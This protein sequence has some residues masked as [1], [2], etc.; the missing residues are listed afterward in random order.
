MK[1]EN[2]QPINF[3]LRTDGFKI[4]SLPN[5]KEVVDSLIFSVQ[6]TFGQ[7]NKKIDVSNHHLFEIYQTNCKIFPKT[8]IALK[9]GKEP[10][11]GSASLLFNDIPNRPQYAPCLSFLWVDRSYQSNGIGSA[12]T[13]IIEK[14]AKN[15]E[16]DHIFLQTSTK[17]AFAFY[18][19]RG[20]KLIENLRIISESHVVMTKAL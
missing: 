7:I 4:Q 18:K 12:L 13:T 3:N 20:W 11:I 6:N 5:N 9:G 16:F 10:A 15:M 2:K 14:Q 17:N 1:I 19:K 8:W